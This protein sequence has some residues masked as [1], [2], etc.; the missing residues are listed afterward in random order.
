MTS[1]APFRP[2]RMAECKA[3]VESLPHGALL[4]RNIHQLSDYPAHLT[5]RFDHWATTAPDRIW[6]AAR[7]ERGA[8]QTVTYAQARARARKIAAALLQRRLSAERPLVILS[9]N[10]ISHALLA[11]ASHY[12]GIPYAPV[13]PAYSLISS[14]FAKLKYIFELLTPGLVFVENTARYERAIER[15]VPIDTE[16]IAEH[17]TLMDRRVTPFSEMETTANDAAVDAA[18]ARITPDTIAKF[19]FTSGSTGVPKAVIN[20]QRMLCAN[21]E[22]MTEHFAY[23]RDEPPVTLDWA[24]WNHTAGG[25]HNFNL[26][27]YNGGTLYI[28]EGKPAPGA[29]EATVRNLREVSPNWYFN[30]P[31]GYDA[32]IPYLRKD[33]ALC[34]N[35]FRNLKLFWYAGAG[36]AQ[37]IWDTLDELSVETTGERITIL[38]GLG[39]TETAPFAMG[40]NDTMVG[41]GLVGLPARGCDFKLVPSR[42]QVRSARAR[43]KYHAR[44]LAPAG[45]DTAGLRRRRL[46]PARRRA[47]L[48][49]SQRRQQGLLFRRPCCGGFQTLNRNLGHGRPVARGAD[50]SLRALYPGRCDRRARPRIYPVLIF[51]DVENCR[52]L[53]GGVPGGLPEM[54]AHPAVRAKF[55]EMLKSFATQATGSSNRV[56]RAMLMSEGPSIDTSE[57]TD[58]GSLNQRAV[59]KNRAAIVDMLYEEIAPKDAICVGTTAKT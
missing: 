34:E 14:D 2:L 37:H 54:A 18:S 52:A 19:L 3:T 9:G 8:W 28:D 58:K 46:L 26:I 43:A 12:A 29:I 40:A 38:T 56:A 55:A 10:G 22:Q 6:L 39:S 30:V 16:I 45:T 24:P 32:L 27:L 36:M 35:F 57:M 21:A 42:R 44:L 49:R 4:V 33:R 23:F 11:L 1:K 47:A 7:A 31:K 13:S 20:T 17:C 41:A 25:N 53:A 15:A 48:C 59:L 50:R 51:P 5:L